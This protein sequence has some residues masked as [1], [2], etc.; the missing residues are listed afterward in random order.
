MRWEGIDGRDLKKMRRYRQTDGGRRRQ[1]RVR[2]K[3]YWARRQTKRKRGGVKVKAER[4]GGSAHVEKRRRNT[5]RTKAKN[6]Y[7][8]T[9][10]MDGLRGY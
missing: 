4:E 6:E 10:E 1:K 3:L 9:A 5:G 2:E 8:K 7:E